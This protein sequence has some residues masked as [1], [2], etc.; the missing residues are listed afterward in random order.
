MT[1]HCVN[2]SDDRQI[3]DYWERE[4]ARMALRYGRSFTGNQWDKTKSAVA[5]SMDFS[6]PRNKRYKSWTLP[7]ITVWTKPGEHHEIKHKEPTKYG[8]FGLEKYRF[9]ALLWMAEETGQNVFYTIHNHALNGGRSNKENNPD[10]W[11]TANVLTLKT[12]KRREAI[13]PSWVNGEKKQVIIYYWDA[14]NW[15]R[16]LDLWRLLPA[17]AVNGGQQ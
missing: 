6:M 11:F 5:H 2:L 12:A 15:V 14:S 16:L 1:E 17:T 3:G 9:E 4:F 13:G 10:H 7:D 8:A